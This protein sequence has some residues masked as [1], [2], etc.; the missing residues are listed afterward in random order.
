M[1]EHMDIIVRETPDVLLMANQV[2]PNRMK[3]V[4]LTYKE[5]LEQGYPL[6]YLN[7]EYNL[8]ETKKNIEA[9]MDKVKVLNLENCMFDLKTMLEYFDGLFFDFEKERL[10]KKVFEEV[11][12]DFKKKI[13]KTNKLVS[14]VYLQ[15]DDIK[16][17]YDLE[18]QD[19]EIIHEVN[20]I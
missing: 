6:D 3:E 13:E 19:V 16:H 11:N 1:I 5:M 4:D 2:I 18:E 20:K 15:L 9:C 7:I 12:K 10:S 14:D 8:E 17:M